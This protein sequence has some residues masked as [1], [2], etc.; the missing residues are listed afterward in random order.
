MR[1]CG[2][3]SGLR[4]IKPDKTRSGIAIIDQDFIHIPALDRADA[5]E[6]RQPSLV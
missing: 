4:N 1:R 3:N 5:S 6:R 2:E